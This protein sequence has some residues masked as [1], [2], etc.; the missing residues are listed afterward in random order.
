METVV[1]MIGNR[2][3]STEEFVCISFII[4]EGDGEVTGGGCK[5]GHGRGGPHNNPP[6]KVI[7]HFQFLVLSHLNFTVEKAR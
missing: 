6:K 7:C 2:T 4:Q 1:F 3:S 5:S